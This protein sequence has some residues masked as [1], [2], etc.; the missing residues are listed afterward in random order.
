[1]RD[2]GVKTF[3]CFDQRRE[4]FKQT[5]PRRRLD[6]FHD[7]SQTL[8]FDC[9]IAARAKLRSSFGKQQPKEMINLR[10]RCDGRFP[11]ATSNTLLDRHAWWQT[12]NKINIRF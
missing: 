9:Q 12:F 8:L 5:A 7:H 3:P 4:N 1:M 10:Y 2:T 11:A 6:L